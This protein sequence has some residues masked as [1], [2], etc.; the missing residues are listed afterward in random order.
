[1]AAFKLNPI[2]LSMD[3]SQKAESK[4]IFLKEVSDRLDL[5]N[6][7]SSPQDMIEGILN[8]GNAHNLNL[9]TRLFIRQMAELVWDDRSLSDGQLRW[10]TGC[11]CQCVI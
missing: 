1:M 11:Y 9:K 2:Q 10:L 4:K 3:F 8:S 5:H 7:K 6:F